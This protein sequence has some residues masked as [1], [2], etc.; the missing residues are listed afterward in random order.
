MDPIL[1]AKVRLTGSEEAA[2][3]FGQAMQRSAAA[4][5]AVS[6]KMGAQSTQ[7]TQEADKLLSEAGLGPLQEIRQYTSRHRDE[8]A[9]ITKD[10][11]AVGDE[12]KPLVA[13]QRRQR[14]GE[15]ARI[16][17]LLRRAAAR[18]SKGVGA[19]VGDA[20]AAVG[21]FMRQF[22]SALPMGVGGMLGI[23]LY[24]VA[25]TQE[26]EAQS[27]RFQQIFEQSMRTGSREAEGLDRSAAA[28]MSKIAEELELRHAATRQEIEAVGQ[29]YAT[30][31]IGAGEIWGRLENAIGA[32]QSTL[33]GLTI[34][35]E[36]HFEL[37][38]GTAA[39]TAGEFMQ[40]YG[41]DVNA[42]A[43]AT[44]RLYFAGA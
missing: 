9:Q 15:S 6:A 2:T 35:L 28:K 13:A 14:G 19:A 30:M 43:G 36:R 24:G 34:S 21:G 23:M 12:L 31:G 17:K 20:G 44:T 10:F 1:E 32:E 11:K 26:L 22:S 41:M 5:D 3:E 37:V 7:K 16:A 4:V 25:K 33:F 42:A 38:G 8:L 29:A 39:K 40:K 27:N 18:V